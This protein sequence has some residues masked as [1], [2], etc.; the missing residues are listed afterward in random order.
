MRISRSAGLAVLTEGIRADLL[1][2]PIKVTT[3]YP[4]YIRTPHRHDF[5]IAPPAP[6]SDRSA[7]KGTSRVNPLMPY[8]LGV[9]A[10]YRRC[11]REALIAGPT[12]RDAGGGSRPSRWP[13]P[14]A[15]P[16]PRRPCTAGGSVPLLLDA[17]PPAAIT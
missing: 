7:T 6:S 3:I 9:W 12:C 10:E 16:G 17:V 15:A 1:R 8:L 5:A 2:T 14:T 11:P 4:G 13:Q